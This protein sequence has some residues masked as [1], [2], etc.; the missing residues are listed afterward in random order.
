MV[1]FGTAGCPLDFYDSGFQKSEQM[2]KYLHDIGLQAFEYQCGRGVR[3][4]DKKADLL[5]A[6]AKQYGITLS[7]HAPYYI[8]LGTNDIE[9]REKSLNYII[10]SAAAAKK[11]GADRVVVHTGSRLKFERSQAMEHVFIAMQRALQELEQCKLSDITICPETMGQF[12][13]LGD[14]S[15]VIALC[16]MDERL[17]PTIDFGHLYCR[18]LGQLV[19]K[20]Q[21]ITELN[22]YIKELGMKKMK[23]FH[24]HFSKMEYTQKGGEKRHVTFADET[25]GPDFTAVAEA[26]QELGLEPRIICESAGTQGIDAQTMKKIYERLL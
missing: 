5:K 13:Q 4:S 24:S 2:P 22:Q 18:S 25:C 23:H 14:S 3:V 21:W 12:N 15:E 8:S 6:A 7:V 1:K 11:M 26:L 10:D 19:T 9:K 17:I 20:Q 16:K